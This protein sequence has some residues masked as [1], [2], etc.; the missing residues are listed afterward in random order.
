MDGFSR[1]I[2]CGIAGIHLDILGCS[3]SNSTC[4]ILSPKVNSTIILANDRPAVHSART[5]KNLD[6]EK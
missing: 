5:L 1:I 4:N 6:V 2:P 3:G